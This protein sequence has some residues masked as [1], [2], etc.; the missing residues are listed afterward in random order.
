MLSRGVILCQVRCVHLSHKI[1]LLEADDAFC[2][3]PPR[4]SAPP[5]LSMCTQVSLDSGDASVLVDGPASA[6]P[7]SNNNN[8]NKDS[9]AAAAAAMNRSAV[10]ANPKDANV[11]LTAA[12]D[13]YLR[14]WSA[15]GHRL[16][17]KLAVGA[18]LAGAVA[19]AAPAAPGVGA[20]EWTPKGSF[21]AC[22][23]MT[24]DVVLV[25]PDNDMTVLSR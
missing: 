17:A 15:D 20:V 23:L 13:G 11:F 22:G 14:K 3:L 1:K 5:P 9:S 18:T 24:G 25:S 2:H 4:A 16:T 8:N 12:A 19:G 10:T 21:V 6:L 7:T